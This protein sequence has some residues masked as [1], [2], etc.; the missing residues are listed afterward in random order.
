MPGKLPSR[1]ESVDKG[2]LSLPS[3]SLMVESVT[4]ENVRAGPRAECPKTSGRNRQTSLLLIYKEISVQ[5]REN[6]VN[7][8]STRFLLLPP[9]PFALSLCTKRK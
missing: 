8:N 2:S 1:G 6:L 4:P 5:Y 7:Y 3:H 9:A